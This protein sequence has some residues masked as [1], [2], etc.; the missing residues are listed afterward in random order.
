MASSIE[1]L[2]KENENYQNKISEL[3]NSLSF[4]KKLVKD[5]KEGLTM[6]HDRRKGS[7]VTKFCFNFHMK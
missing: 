7:Q 2:K 3:N 6:Q 4:Y 5:E 1:D